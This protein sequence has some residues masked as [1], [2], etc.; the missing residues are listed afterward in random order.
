MTMMTGLSASSVSALTD[1]MFVPDKVLRADC[2]IVLG[3]TLF[4]RPVARALQ[5]QAQG[6]AGRVIFS[7]GY[8]PRLESFEAIEMQKEWHRLGQDMD[9]V[10]IETTS[11][12]TRENMSHVKFLLEDKGW[13]TGTRTVNLIAI[14]YHMRR[15]LETFH[16]VFGNDLNLGTASYPSQHCPPLGWD[17]HPKGRDL[18]VDEF[19]K[20]Y[21]YLPHRLTAEV[22]SLARAL[23]AQA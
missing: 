10:Q 19:L 13:L 22:V 16:D 20:I 17:R 4:H 5:L 8:N 18:V 11:T 21:Q 7:G 3:M 9:L 15:A 23:A 6:L 14:S 12:N 2:T 1:F